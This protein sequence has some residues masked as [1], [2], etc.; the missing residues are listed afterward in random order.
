ME[1]GHETRLKK[2]LP[3]T[4]VYEFVKD[5][6]SKGKKPKSLEIRRKPTPKSGD[7][8]EIKCTAE[9]VKPYHGNFFISEYPSEGELLDKVTGI[10]NVL[11]RLNPGIGDKSKLI[12]ILRGD[13]GLN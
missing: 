2:L 3:Y 6:R 9:K 5:C 10:V 13:I 12:G 1:Y 4:D 7:L 11:K 8:L